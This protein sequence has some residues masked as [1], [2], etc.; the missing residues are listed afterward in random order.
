[1]TIRDIC[2]RNQLHLLHLP[3]I[4]SQKHCPDSGNAKCSF[5]F[6][7]QNHHK[8]VSIPFASMKLFSSGS[9]IA[10]A[11]LNPVN[12]FLVF[13]FFT[14]NYIYSSICL[15]VYWTSS[16]CIAHRKINCK[17]KQYFHRNHVYFPLSH[18]PFALATKTTS[19]NP[20]IHSLNPILSF[21]SQSRF[22][23]SWKTSDYSSTPSF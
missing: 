18:L 2:R 9:Q 7:S 6:Y 11:L 10:S 12:I 21:R 22:H 8:L 23:I 14:G 1:M 15:S 3:R 20:N 17:M 19:H 16:S 5:F 13:F 4:R